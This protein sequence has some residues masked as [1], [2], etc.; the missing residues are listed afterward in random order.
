MIPLERAVVARLKKGGKTF[1]VLVDPEGAYAFKRKD[2]GVSIGDILA[3][4]DVFENASRGERPSADAIK[5]AFGTTDVL[6]VAEHIVR[7]GEI[8]ITAEQRRKIQEEKRRQVVDIIARNAIN[9]QTGA[10]HPP[11]RIEKAMETAGVSIDISK[12]TDA[13]VS[14]TMKAIRPIIPIRF[15][16]V[17]IA[18]KIPAQFTGRAY[19]QLKPL[20]E[21]LGEEWLSDGSLALVVEVPAGLQ[22]ELYSVVNHLTHGEAETKILR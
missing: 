17:K 9:P 13:L 6:E 2:E 11:A 5:S 20:G 1:E 22:D 16:T 10:P 4:E 12:S 7:R 3:V 8:H 19:G 15:D 21:V 18:V 14:A